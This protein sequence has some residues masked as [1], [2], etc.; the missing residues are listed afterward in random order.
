M[1]AAMARRQKLRQQLSFEVAAA[2]ATAV[3]TFVMS[4]PQFLLA[5]VVAPLSPRQKK[6]LT[7]FVPDAFAESFSITPAA[8]AEA[9]MRSGSGV[10]FA[11]SVS[12]TK[13]TG[14]GRTVMVP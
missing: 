3:L 1:P 12:Q 14:E 13:E 7:L 9:A 4:A 5:I 8:A 6:P 11:A 2:A 10:I